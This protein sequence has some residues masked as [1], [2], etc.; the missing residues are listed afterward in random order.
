MF[1]ICHIFKVLLALYCDFVLQSGDGAWT[2]SS[3]RHHQ[4]MPQADVFHSIRIPTG[5]F[6][7]P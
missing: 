7:L 4:Q 3:S 5:F 2:C 6:R 1:E